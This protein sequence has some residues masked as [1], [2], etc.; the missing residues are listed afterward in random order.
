MREG[1]L[2]VLLKPAQEQV[3][4]ESV[5]NRSEAGAI[6]LAVAE[7]ARLARE[8]WQLA[9][10]WHLTQKL[11]SFPLNEDA[12]AFRDWSRHYEEMTFRRKPD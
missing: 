5:V 11:K 6:L 8:A 12:R 3:L 2:P 4:W 7:T 10:A 9:H 1:R